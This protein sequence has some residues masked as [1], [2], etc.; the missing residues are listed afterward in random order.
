MSYDDLTR[1]GKGICDSLAAGD[2]ADAADPIIA[3][4]FN[5]GSQGVGSV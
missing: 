3:D 1:F 5:Y 4:Y 2:F